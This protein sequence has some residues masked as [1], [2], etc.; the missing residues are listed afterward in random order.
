MK[1]V[2]FLETIF[3]KIFFGGGMLL[4]LHLFSS[5]QYNTEH[6]WITSHNI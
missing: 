6:G 4:F 2:N 1:N 5:I 3:K